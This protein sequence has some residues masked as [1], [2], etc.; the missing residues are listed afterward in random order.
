MKLTITKQFQT[1]LKSIGIEFEN[2]LKKAKI[3][4]KL[5]QEEISLNTL[6]Y[7]NML[8]ELDK[9]VPESAVRMLSD[10]DNI[11]MFMPPFFAALSS[12]NG[13]EAI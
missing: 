12:L 1:F 5:W 10:I 11:S 2:I 6:E 3:P 8:I 13:K 9:E 4:N 7:Y